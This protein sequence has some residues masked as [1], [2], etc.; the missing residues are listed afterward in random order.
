M[1]PNLKIRFLVISLFFSFF[2]YSQVVEQFLHGSELIINGLSF[3]KSNK[4]EKVNNS[5]TIVNVCVKNKLTDKITFNLIGKVEEGN[6]IK[7]DLVIPKDGKECLLELPKGIY[8]YEIVL[9][10]KEVFKK[11]EYKFIEEITITIKDD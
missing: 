3:L 4:S 9:P 8:T 5:K 7:K 6:T 11:G 2:T 1:Y 10:N